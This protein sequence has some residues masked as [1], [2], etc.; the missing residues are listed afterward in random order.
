M[1]IDSDMVVSIDW[2]SFERNL[3][4]LKGGYGAI[5]GLHRAIVGGFGAGS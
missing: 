3:G 2:R 1:D 5:E 4:I